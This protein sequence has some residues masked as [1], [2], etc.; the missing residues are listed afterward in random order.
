MFLQRFKGT[1]TMSKVSE[2]VKTVKLND[3]KPRESR[4][5]ETLDE[6]CGSLS[7]LSSSSTRH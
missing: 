7:T 4:S 3:E 1:E 5:E 6:V 2:Q